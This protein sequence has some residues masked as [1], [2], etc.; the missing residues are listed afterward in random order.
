MLQKPGV[1]RRLPAGK[2]DFLAVEVPD[3]GAV[4]IDRDA[5]KADLSPGG[6]PAMAALSS[7]T[8]VSGPADFLGVF[9]EHLHQAFDARHQAE[10]LEALLHFLPSHFLHL[11]DAGNA[12][13]RI[14][15]CGSLLHG[16]A[17]HFGLNTPSLRLEESNA[18]LTAN[19][20]IDRDIP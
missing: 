18:N 4:D 3:P 10:A 11:R 2:W 17:L 14:D 1:P 7:P 19:F 15:G 12:G 5:V 9:L 6:S 20:Y 8:P 16:V 13:E